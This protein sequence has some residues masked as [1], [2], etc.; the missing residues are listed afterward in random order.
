ML[1]VEPSDIL[2]HNFIAVAN[3]FGHSPGTPFP[4][5]AP[6]N[7]CLHACQR[8]ESS[9]ISKTPVWLLDYSLSRLSGHEYVF[10]P[11]PLDDLGRASNHEYLI[12]GLINHH[13]GPLLH[14]SGSHNHH[15]PLE[16]HVAIHQK[17]LQTTLRTVILYIPSC[18]IFFSVFSPT[19]SNQID[20]LE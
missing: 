20:D 15:K 14:Q 1:M 4:D 18:N 7:I 10:D 11:F 16:E 3:S 17:S 13:V 8:W 19:I 9:V 6:S 12:D 5:S 2:C